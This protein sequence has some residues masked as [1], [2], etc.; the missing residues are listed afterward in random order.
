LIVG[1][2][3]KN[4]ARLY[5]GKAGIVDKDIRLTWKQVDQR[6]NSLVNALAGLG[7][8]KGDRVVIISENNHYYAEFLLSVAKSGF[9]GIGVSYR[10]TPQQLAAV[11]NDC[12]PRAILCQGKFSSAINEV[13]SQVEGVDYL[14]GVGEGHG[15]PL[16]YDTLLAEAPGDSIEADVDENDTCLII[17]TTGTI[18]APKG[19]ITTHRI[20]FSIL[21][22]RLLAYRLSADDVYLVHGPLYLAGGLQHFFTA[23]LAGTTVVIESFS[24][25]KFTELIEREKVTV[26]HLL[27]VHYKLLRDHLETT[28]HKND[29][30]S[31]KKLAFGAGQAVLAE[32]V[33][34]ILDFF[35]V[36]WS[37]K[38]YGM[39][40]GIVSFLMSEDI[41]AGLSPSAS[42][43]Q[44]RRLDSVGKP[45][46]GARVR[47]VDEDDKDVPRGEVGEILVKSD[48]WMAGYWNNPDLSRQVM[49]NGW[50]HTS[51][52]GMFDEDGYLYLVGRKDALI[53]SGGL[54]VAPREVEDVI[55][56]HPVVAEVAVIGVP[57]KAWGQIVK[58]VVCLKEGEQATEEE[59]RE[60]CRHH[61]ASYQVP[62]VVDFATKLPKDP[63]Y[64]KVSLKELMKIYG[65]GEA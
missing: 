50:Y 20:W 16:D 23:C 9:I 57:D 35:G 47:I 1:D 45:V 7:L 33:R 39:T 46:F 54:F 13:K 17:Y 40:E 15:F 34:D 55:L 2:I 43:S 18:G 59:I 25:G 21:M 38:L 42:D 49:R 28:G 62:R 41:A 52:M 27:P 58:A 44:R 51:D 8:Q 11:I 48:Y 65:R 3:V 36:S 37:N 61:L 22:T 60:H 53:K 32:Q 24:A 63:V 19:V 64:G 14:I 6:T 5:P 4:N 31:L 10:F 12:R 26:S 29:L 30:S 56:Q